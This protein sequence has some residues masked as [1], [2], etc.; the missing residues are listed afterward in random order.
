MDRES[1]IAVLV[2]HYQRPRNKGA[3]ENADARIP[4]GNP[5]CGDLITMYMKASP[6]G[7]TIEKVSFEGAGCTISQAAAS[8]LTERVNKEHWTFAEALSFTPERMM[9]ILGRDIVDARPGCATLALGTLKAAVK[10]IETD[11]ALRAAG[12]SEAE[13][14]R[15]REEVAAK[16]AGPAFVVGE[17]ATQLT[18][19]Q[20]EEVK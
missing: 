7:E 15:L 19:E 9:D 4:G 10:T 8:I 3:L 14:R 16:A 13:I 6:T 1:R 18:P 2:D 12:K 11:R 20:H 5:G 17:A